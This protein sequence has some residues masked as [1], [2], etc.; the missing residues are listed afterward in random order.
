MTADQY[1][2]GVCNIGEAEIAQRKR[3]GYIA[4]VVTLVGWALLWYSGVPALWR[5]VLVI[6]AA[7]SATGFLQGFMHFCAGF[8]M[9][10]TFNFGPELY[11]TETVKQAEFRAKDKRKA[12]TIFA[13][14]VAI[15]IVVAAVAY[16]L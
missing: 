13:Y 3:I 12:Q 11:K 1:I 10:G 7:M 9:R 16:F 14:S 5:L 6:P 15:G 8:G 4:L 2:P